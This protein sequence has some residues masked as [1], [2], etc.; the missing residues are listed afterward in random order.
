[1]LRLFRLTKCFGQDAPDADR[2]AHAERTARV[3][4]AA[5]TFALDRERTPAIEEIGGRTALGAAPPGAM[6]EIL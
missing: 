1:M 4:R 3:Q 2:R 5:A 6:E